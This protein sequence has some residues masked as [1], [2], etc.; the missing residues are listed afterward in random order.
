MISFWVD[1]LKGIEQYCS[2]L[3][4]WNVYNA[5]EALLLSHPEL[6]SY[7][8]KLLTVK[9]ET[10]LRMEVDITFEDKVKGLQSLAV[11]EIDS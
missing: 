5:V 1:C 3:S 11:I 8:I 6:F 4:A 7:R 9:V 10:A 2:A